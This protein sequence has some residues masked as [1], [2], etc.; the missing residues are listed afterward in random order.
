MV[1]LAR[2]TSVLVLD[3]QSGVSILEC[4]SRPGWSVIACDLRPLG[5]VGQNF[6]EEICVLM[7]P[8]SLPNCLSCFVIERASGKNTLL[9]VSNHNS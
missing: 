2:S 6:V 5:A 1:S 9:L 3:P 4:K 7:I 8:V